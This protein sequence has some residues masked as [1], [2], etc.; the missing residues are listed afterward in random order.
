MSNFVSQKRLLLNAQHFPETL[1]VSSLM[2][3]FIHVVI[4]VLFVFQI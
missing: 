2:Y 1:D 4:E 3:G